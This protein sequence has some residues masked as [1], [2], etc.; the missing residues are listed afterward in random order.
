[1]TTQFIVEDMFLIQGKGLVVAGVLEGERHGF[2]TGARVS[3][4]HPGGRRLV[5]GVRGA[6]LLRGF[7]GGIN[8]CLLLEDAFAPEEVPR[9]SV[10]ALEAA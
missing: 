5:S 1:M 9:D 2:H 4:S 3:I 10:I 7:S 8:I 6:E